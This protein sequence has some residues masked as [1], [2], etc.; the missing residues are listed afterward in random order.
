MP[1]NSIKH[2]HPPS[3]HASYTNS[4][5]TGLEPHHFPSSVPVPFPPRRATSCTHPSPCGQSEFPQ[6]S[7]LKRSPTAFANPFTPIH[8]D[9]EPFLSGSPPP[10]RTAA[11]SRDFSILAFLRADARTRLIHGFARGELLLDMS[12]SLGQIPLRILQNQ[13]SEGLSWKSFSDPFLLSSFGRPVFM[14]RVL[15][16]HSLHP[17]QWST[18]CLCLSSP[19]NPE[20]CKRQQLLFL[21]SFKKQL[22]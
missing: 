17:E 2:S 9:T 22:P 10:C 11:R 19:A 12:H 20:V 7:C 1:P 21:R 6:N 13:R 5:G 3:R 4:L 16:S 18:V 15:S 14:S 8:A